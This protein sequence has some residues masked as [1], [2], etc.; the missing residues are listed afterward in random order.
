LS[1]V[2]VKSDR[3]AEI[4][5]AVKRLVVSLVANHP[6]IDRIIW[7]GS[8]VRGDYGPQSDVDLCLILSSSTKPR[9]ADRI[10][11]FLPDAFPAGIDVLPYTREEFD[12]LRIEQ[13]AWW[14]AVNAGFVLYPCAES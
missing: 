10:P 11:D 4:E 12:R 8:R 3:Q 5:A 13:P 9:I 2:V 7:F 6:E 1:S 14:A